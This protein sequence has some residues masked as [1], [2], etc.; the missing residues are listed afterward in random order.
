M[1]EMGSPRSRYELVQKN[2]L[3]ASVCHTMSYM[4]DVLTIRIPKKLAKELKGLCDQQGRSASDVVR[5]SLRRYI[6]TEHLRQIREE[7]RPYAEAKG[8][9]TDEDVFKLLK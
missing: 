8:V 1:A 4:N 7:L 6:V 2:L 9:F 3:A 5:E